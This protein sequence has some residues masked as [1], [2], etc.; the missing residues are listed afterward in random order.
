MPKKIR[1]G[2]LG[3]GGD[4]LIGILHRVASQINDNFEIVGGCFNP[5]FKVNKAFARE[6]DVPLNRIYTDFDTLIEEEL[7]HP[8]TIS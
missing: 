6:I 4:S 1:L 3:G 5:D 7:K 8:P 2:V